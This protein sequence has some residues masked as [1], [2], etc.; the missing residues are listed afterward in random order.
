[1][2]YIVHGFSCVDIIQNSTVSKLSKL[3]KVSRI[4]SNRSKV[5]GCCATSI[6]YSR[7]S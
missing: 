3:S 1:M 6:S 5:S 2:K 4:L 7:V